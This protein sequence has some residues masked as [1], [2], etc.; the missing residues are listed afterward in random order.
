MSTHLFRLKT[1]DQKRSLNLQDGLL[2][3]LNAD[4]IAYFLAAGSA[5]F[6]AVTLFVACLGSFNFVHLKLGVHAFFAF[7]NLNERAK[8]LFKSLVLLYLGHEIL[9]EFFKVLTF[10][11]IQTNNVIADTSELINDI[12]DIWNTKRV[13]CWM[14]GEIDAFLV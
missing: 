8:Y 14:V 7:F 3:F 13:L 9:F 12:N 11:S 4:L 2:K 1:E 6:L 10:N 5:S